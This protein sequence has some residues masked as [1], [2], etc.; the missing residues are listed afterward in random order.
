[1]KNLKNKKTLIAVGY[2]FSPFLESQKRETET[3]G[4]GRTREVNVVFILACSD[5][6]GTSFF[7]FFFLIENEVQVSSS[8]GKKLQ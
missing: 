1:M 2:S 6:L 3:E 4:R 5:S 7:R 8:L